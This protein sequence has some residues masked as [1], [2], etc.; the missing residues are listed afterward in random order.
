MRL[1][2][3][4]NAIERGLPEGWDDA[5]LS[6]EVDEWSD[7]DRAAALLAPL[8]PGRSGRAVRFFCARRGAGP[9]PGAVRR[10]L[11]R[12]DRERIG[13]RLDLLAAGEPALEPRAERATLAA[14]WDAALQTLP[15]DWS[16]LYVEVELRSTD[17]LERAALL[18]APVNPARHGGRPGFRFRVA[19]LAGYGASPAMTR[20]CFE[21]LDR[22]NVRGTIAI[23]RALSET[24]H[25]AT[26]GPVWYVGG[27][28][29]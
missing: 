27:R 18:L 8:A 13:G 16:D 7:A 11:E 5:R 24:R 6:L 1:V 2:E 23:L 15:G 19:R 4:W 28:A 10:A 17:Q 3:Q 9:G 21:R 26:Q 22:E 14:S 20:R 12:L 25:V 29:V